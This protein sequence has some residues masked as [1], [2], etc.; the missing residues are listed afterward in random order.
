[1]ILLSYLALFLAIHQSRTKLISMME[2]RKI[3]KTENEN[4][5]NF[6]IVKRSDENRR[7]EGGW[8]AAEGAYRPRKRRL[9]RVRSLIYCQPDCPSSMY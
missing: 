2:E 6:A 1:M 7:M 3:D 4:K 9:Q 5:R 8:K